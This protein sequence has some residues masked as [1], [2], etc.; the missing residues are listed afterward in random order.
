[1]K[2]RHAGY[3]F[4]ILILTITLFGCYVNTYPTFIKY[5]TKDGWY[6]EVNGIQY[7]L[8]PDDKWELLDREF[9]NEIGNLENERTGLYE[10]LNDKERNYLQVGEA[11]ADLLH[12]PLVKRELEDEF[13]LDCVDSIEWERTDV[14][15]D[16]LNGNVGADTVQD[17]AAIKRLAAL[18]SDLKDDKL[19]GEWVSAGYIY[20]YNDKLPGAV[21]TIDVE[22]CNDMLKCRSNDT[23]K[24]S[25]IPIAEL[26][27][28]FGYKQG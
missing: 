3:V 14:Y 12:V 22:Y 13:S 25:L 23:N 28:I 8:W 9:G 16:Y 6:T 4:I 10:T 26:E 27:G 20:C 19:T 11:G 1:M 15:I 2:K 24:Y 5:K 7:V 17:S 21:Y 18:T